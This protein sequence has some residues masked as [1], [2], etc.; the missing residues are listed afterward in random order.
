VDPYSFPFC[1]RKIYSLSCF[2]RRIKSALSSL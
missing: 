1:S 2:S